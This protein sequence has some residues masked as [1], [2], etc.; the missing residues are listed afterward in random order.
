MVFVQL[1][2][3]LIADYYNFLSISE[4]IEENNLTF[5]DLPNE[6]CT[7]LFELEE[8]Y[9]VKIG[10]AVRNNFLYRTASIE[11]I[12]S[13]N[14]DNLFLFDQMEED[15][16]FGIVNFE[17]E[18]LVETKDLDSDN[19]NNNQER[20]LI[21]IKIEPT[22][23]IEIDFKMLEGSS[24][25]I[26][27]F[28]CDN[29]LNL[30]VRWNQWR[31]RLEQYFVAGKITDDAQ[32]KAF[33]FLFGGRRLNE[34]HNNLPAEVADAGADTEYKKSIARLKAYF[35]PKRNK[36]VEVY[37]FR[38]TKQNQN[39]TIDQFVTRLRGL[40]RYCEFGDTNIDDEILKQLIQGCSS[41]RVRRKILSEKK[42]NLTKA[43]ETCRLH[44][45]VE[46][47]AGYFE[48]K[49]RD[50]ENEHVDL[51]GRHPMNKFKDKNNQPNT[52]KCYFSGGKYPHYNS[53]PAKGKK[54]N[55]CDKMN[56]FERCCP[57]VVLSVLDKE[58]KF[59]IDTGADINIIDESTFNRFNKLPKLKPKDTDQKVIIMCISRTLSD[60]EQRYSQIELEALAPVWSMERLEVCLI[61]KP[62]KLFCDNRAISLIFNNPLSKPP[63]RIQRW[64]L[65]L[66][67]F[68]F[69]VIHVPGK[70]NIADF[71]S[72]HPL[73][74]RIDDN[75]DNDDYVNM[76]VD[77]SIPINLS[78]D[79]IKEETDKDLKLKKLK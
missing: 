47:Q 62:F 25:L 10:S 48:N 61:G 31:E 14:D 19:T 66:A 15:D 12:E 23:P 18:Y 2:K 22:Q 20:S 74:A 69:K 16:I 35:E 11:T 13:T 77:C 41:N 8:F 33:L 39:E 76:I 45:S 64:E 60:T 50:F 75:I 59:K 49:Q 6:I 65:R 9:E 78:K 44:D 17:C 3:D 5:M 36:V 57:E 37:L 40:A 32:K 4:L 21:D 46:T 67:P 27:Q 26:E 43:L 58:I 55:Y 71:L 28:D 30:N 24:V 34:I 29:N 73:K 52:S 63:A 56:H 72:R 51:V 68:E 1:S 38:Q 70:G 42:L 7:K 53:C 54:C 79:E